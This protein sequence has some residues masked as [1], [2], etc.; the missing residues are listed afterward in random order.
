MKF[1]RHDSIN[2]AKYTK[3]S[4]LFLFAII[5]LAVVSC[6]ALV[7]EKGNLFALND[8]RVAQGLKLPGN[9]F[10][11]IGGGSSGGGSSVITVTYKF[12]GGSGTSTS[13]FLISTISDLKNLQTAVANDYVNS[14]LT[15]YCSMYYKM[16]NNITYNS[17]LSPIGSQTYPFKGNFDGSN[18]AIEDI[19]FNSTA[20]YVGLFGHTSGAKISNLTVFGT[21]TGSS[22]SVYVAGIVAYASSGTEINNC[23]NYCNV[24]N[25]GSNSE[26][27]YYA[28]GIVAC[29]DSSNSVTIYT[30]KNFG[31]ISCGTSSGTYNYVAAGLCGYNLRRCQWSFNNGEIVAGNT[32]ANS[33]YACGIC[34]GGSVGVV[35]YCFNRGNIK[36]Y[37]KRQSD[38]YYFTLN[39]IY[40]KNSGSLMKLDN[41]T[42]R[43]LTSEELKEGKYSYDRLYGDGDNGT[44]SVF[45]YPSNNLSTTLSGYTN[46]DFQQKVVTARYAFACGISK[47]GTLS[48]CYNTGTIGSGSINTDGFFVTYWMYNLLFWANYD[49]MHLKFEWWYKTSFCSPISLSDSASDSYY[50]NF[51]DDYSGIAMCVTIYD[52]SDKTAIKAKENDIT[53][54]DGEQVSI[55]SSY[56]QIDSRGRNKF[57]YIVTKNSWNTNIVFKIQFGASSTTTINVFECGEQYNTSVF[58]SHSYITYE[59]SEK[60]HGTKSSNL[61]SEYSSTSTYQSDT[62]I[63]NGYKYI[64]SMYW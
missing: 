40:K 12:S 2:S 27:Y 38:T 43:T 47:G 36:A 56:F 49:E 30:C 10:V 42:E 35:S 64:S 4:M 9:S 28:G 62:I 22:S 46:S 18:Y 53:I 15:N 7:F 20:K 50:D 33:S 1:N 63:N 14:S 44:I 55:T 34:G 51:T 25:N 48:F 29:S 26:S 5:L 60:Q 11:D 39:G 24:T 52:S 58:N 31:N 41:G 6:I 3:I 57:R 61:K 8:S 37:A 45:S 32:N 19:A 54:F 16:T 23:T 13:P 21:V 17:S 59:R